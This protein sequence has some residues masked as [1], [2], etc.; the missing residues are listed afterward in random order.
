MR[1][2]RETKNSRIQWTPK[3]AYG[4]DRYYPTCHIITPRSFVAL[5]LFSQDP[6]KNLQIGRGKT[7]I[8]RVLACV[9]GD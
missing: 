2:L 3:L 7:T 6:A 8:R 9:P 4:A 1:T 5:L